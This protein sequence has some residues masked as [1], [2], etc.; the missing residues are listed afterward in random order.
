MTLYSRWDLFFLKEVWCYSRGQFPD[1]FQINSFINDFS[2][3]FR[4]FLKRSSNKTKCSFLI[5][6]GSRMDQNWNW[7]FKIHLRRALKWAEMSEVSRYRETFKKRPS[8]FLK[9]KRRCSSWLFLPFSS[10]ILGQSSLRSVEVTRSPRR[11]DQWTA[12]S[13]FFKTAQPGPDTLPPKVCI[14][15]LIRVQTASVNWWGLVA[16][17]SRCQLHLPYVSCLIKIFKSFWFVL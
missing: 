10:I 3:H 7:I 16:K 4:A 14:S 8:L 17:G 15:I 12:L 9:T 1:E 13:C 2:P 5:E 11:L 6:E